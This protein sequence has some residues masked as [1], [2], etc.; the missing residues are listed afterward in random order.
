[1][2]T[3]N[4]SRLLIMV[5][6]LLA[7]A[8]AFAGG[9]YQ[10]YPLTPCRLVDTRLPANA[11][12][13]SSDTTRSFKIRGICGIPADAAAAAVNLAVALPTAKGHIRAFPSDIALPTASN[14]NFAGGENALA[15]GAIIPLPADTGSATDVSV[16]LFMVT[17]GTAHLIIDVTG[18]FK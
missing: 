16:Y 1:M 2:R 4:F 12:I 3:R 17:P 15:N 9:P 14:M 5:A 8:P 11:P 6:L 7:A 10:F 18:Y 13:M